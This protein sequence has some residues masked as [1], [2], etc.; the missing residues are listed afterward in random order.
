MFPLLLLS[1]FIACSDGDTAA[2]PARKDVVLTSNKHPEANAD[3]FSQKSFICC[4]T[5]EASA[6]LE[7]YLAVTKAMAADDDG[8]TK[9]AVAAL[10]NLVNEEPSLYAADASLKELQKGSAYWKTLS[11]KDI[12]AD[13]KEASQAMIDY[14]KKHQSEKGITVIT[15]YCPMADSNTGGR[16]LQTEKTISNP[17]FG[18]MMLTCGV[19]E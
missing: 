2:K 8:K 4:D 12:Q 19:F 14:A 16:W 6:L 11:R 13:F 1:S 3:D 17:Y 5:Q 18:S 7:R 10:A 15:A 9:T